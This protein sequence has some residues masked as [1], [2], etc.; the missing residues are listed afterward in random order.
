MAE[1][2]VD[3]GELLEARRRQR[4]EARTSEMIEGERGGADLK[5]VRKSAPRG[6]RAFL[7]ILAAVVGLIVLGL[8]VKAYRMR[9]HETEKAKTPTSRI[10]KL[11]PSLTREPLPQAASPVQARAGLV[12]TSVV[13]QTPSNPTDSRGPD[14]PAS[15][16]LP[17]AAP[18]PPPAAGA[19][20]SRESVLDR[21][22]SRGFGGLSSDDRGGVGAVSAAVQGTGQGVAQ[23]PKPGGLEEKLA[24]TE[25]E[26]TSARLMENRDYWLT[27]GAILDCVLETK[28]V[29]TV[30]GMTSCHLTRDVYST[31]GRVVLLDRGSKLVGRYQAGMQQGDTR[32]FV[33]WT[34]A[35]T[36]SGVI[37]NLD[38]PGTGALGEAGV[39]GWT[40]QHFWD[41][42]GAAIMVS[43]IGTGADAAAA[44]IAGPARNAT[45]NL[46]PTASATKELVTQNY[47]A[48]VNMPPTLYVNQ[49]ERIGIFVARD[50][51]FRSVYGLERVNRD[52]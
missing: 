1:D 21:R 45:I 10:E 29:T 19:A 35:E 12:P 16:Q 50:L 15:A 34:R 6:A 25:L 36:P 24:V 32:I 8:S 41:R 13:G 46:D 18:A 43:L 40:D 49:G 2:I 3:A 38:S 23:T 9:R 27:Q 37:V 4:E 31:S 22:L 33:V 26:G 39:G 20:A 5:V 11:V 42:F 7:A 14:D 48:T 44:R 52:E 30:P 47:D 51:S 17:P 28:I